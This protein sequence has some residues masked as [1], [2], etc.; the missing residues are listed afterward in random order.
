MHLT[1]RN[2]FFTYS[3]LL[4][5]SMSDVV[6]LYFVYDYLDLVQF[7]SVLSKSNVFSRTYPFFF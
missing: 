1:L 5:V 6:L 3:D 4:N 7:D 2:S